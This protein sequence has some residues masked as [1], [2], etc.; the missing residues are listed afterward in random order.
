MD[1]QQLGQTMRG[2]LLRPGEDGYDDARRVWNARFDRRPD[3]I[4]RCLDADDVAAAVRWAREEAVTISVKGGGHSY[5]GNTVADGGLLIDLSGMTGIK[6]R[7]DERTATVEAGATWKEF[8]S[9]TQHHGLATTGVTVS[10]VG[11]AGST[12]GGGSGWLSRRFGHAL[13]NLLAVELVTADGQRIR[14]SGDEHPD[15]FWALRGA[16][17]N[18][19]VVTSFEFDLHEVGP[20]V[21]AG[22]IVYPFDRAEELMRF[23]RDFMAEAPDEFQCFPFTFRVPP[24]DV[25]PAAFHGQPV[26]DF[27]V[28]HLDPAA[29]DVVQPLRELGETVLDVVGPMPYT[30]AQQAFDPNLPSGQRYY[31]KAHDLADLSDDAIDTMAAHVRTMQGPLTA[32]YL[33]PRGGTVSRIGGA[34]TA[35]GG[36][37]APYSFHILAGWMDPAEDGAVMEW[38]QAFADDMADHATGGV[39][40]NLIAED[41]AER[42]PTAFSDH[43]RLRDLKRQWDP[44]NVFH[45]NHNVPPA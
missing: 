45:N 23:F 14:V 28:F 12:L 30:A 21:L 42:V 17:P 34:T 27:V 26:L 44:D 9:A 10:S 6:V 20:E 3:V 43:A 24:I 22:Q 32:A 37:E 16:G 5:A 15:L 31:S 4:A 18:F 1:S 39:Y 2:A 11:V 33:E 41:E 19:G 13:D 7:P 29:S 36:R 35:A 38:A 40:V 25:F 8:D